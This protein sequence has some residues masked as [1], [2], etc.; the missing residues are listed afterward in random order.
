[1][2]ASTFNLNAERPERRTRTGVLVGEIRIFLL[3]ETIT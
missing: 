1:M 2:I 3:A